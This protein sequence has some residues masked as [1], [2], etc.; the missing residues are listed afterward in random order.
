M[1]TPSTPV[2]SIVRSTGSTPSSVPNGVSPQD[3]TPTSKIKALL[4]AIDEES[5]ADSPA[6]VQGHGR[7]PLSTVSG[8]KRKLDDLENQVPKHTDRLGRA[9]DADSEHEDDEEPAFVP[10]GRMA[11]R[12][13]NQPDLKLNCG[14]SQERSNDENA[15]ARV[16][17]RLAQKKQM[18]GHKKINSPEKQ[19]SPGVSMIGRKDASGIH[20]PSI[21]PAKSHRSSPGLFVSPDKVPQSREVARTPSGSGTLDSDSPIE[22]PDNRRFLELVARKRAEREAKQAAEDQKRKEKDDA[23]RSFEKDLSKDESHVSGSSDEDRSADKRLTQQSRPTRKASKKALEEMNRE[24]QRMSRNMQLAHQVKTKKKI[25]KE[26]LLARFNFRTSVTPNATPSTNQ[27]SSTVVSSDPVSDV[28]EAAQ[29]QS[30]PTSPA[31]PDGHISSP[32]QQLNKNTMLNAVNENSLEQD[33]ELPNISDVM[34]LPALDSYKGKGKAIDCYDFHSD[35]SNKKGVKSVLKQPEIKIRPPRSLMQVQEIDLD[36]DDERQV[37]ATKKFRSSNRD[38]FDRLP[39]T[40]AKEG[41]SLQTL[42]ALAH[43]NSP[44]KQ[45]RG[46]RSTVS[47]AEMQTSLQKRA[48]Q[49]AVEERAAKLEDLRSRGI[50]VQTA[51]ERQQ[52]QAAVEDL[53]EKARRE[54]EEILQ[55]EK[56]AAKKAKIANGE[57]QDLPDTSDEDEDYQAEAEDEL[58]A[59][60]SGS[61]DEEEEAEDPENPDE[62]ESDGEEPTNEDGVGGVPLSGGKSREHDLI[63]D[64]ASEDED[65]DGQQDLGHETEP[66]SDDEESSPEQSMHCP[67]RNNRIIVEDDDDDGDDDKDLERAKATSQSQTPA[68][69]VPMIPIRPSDFDAAPMGLTQAFAATMADTHTQPPE[70]EE[71]Q[72]SLASLDTVPD[73]AIP[74]FDTYDTNDSLQ[75]IPDSQADLQL[76]EPNASNEIKLHLSQFQVQRGDAQVEEVMATQMSEMPD[77]TQDVGFGMSSPAPERFVSEPPLTVDTVLLPGAPDSD[78][79]VKKKGRLWRPLLV[80]QESSDMD[81]DHVASEDGKVEVKSSNNAFDAMKKA[82]KATKAAAAKEAFD[83]KKSEAKGM[84]EEQAQESEDEYAGLGGASDEDSGEEDADVEAMMDH[85]DIEVD[86]RQLA[87]LYA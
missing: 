17:R 26:S 68:I 44:E 65:E 43:L 32:L 48:R 22:K 35:S 29:K 84:V 69:E 37:V 47:L 54:G 53:L 50:I 24:T 5:D 51:E 52:D 34:N 82:R 13:Q 85:S 79:P 28:E 58:E 70:D 78:S 23:R 33:E 81:E 36:S 57:M 10:R 41:R 67:R 6:K 7:K 87:Q 2:R 30:P 20:S 3:L 74:M 16:K 73:P 12:L 46:R 49:Q 31:E 9:E 18:A 77:P 8:N 64:E 72:N 19:S 38:I 56:R 15:Y 4:A 14:S 39:A 1:S 60:L 63:E 59:D 11:A 61:E 27:G 76:L 45:K 42:R 40:K 80:D 62:L 55:K 71:A 66:A 86:E 25:T 83:K 75:M 21:S